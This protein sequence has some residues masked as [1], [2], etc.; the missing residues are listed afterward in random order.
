MGF[1]ILNR[2]LQVFNSATIFS[3]RQNLVKTH[4]C[5]ANKSMKNRVKGKKSRL[6]GEIDDFE[7]ERLALALDRNTNARISEAKGRNSS[8]WT[9]Y[10]VGLHETLKIV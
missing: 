7:M 1:I 5:A 4:Q 2:N 3:T 6:N 9:G 10:Y 8:K